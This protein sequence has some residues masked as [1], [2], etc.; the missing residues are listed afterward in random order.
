[1]TIFLQNYIVMN[2]I[3]I[4]TLEK[5]SQNIYTFVTLLLIY[6]DSNWNLLVAK[7]ESLNILG[8]SIRKD[9]S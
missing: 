4:K 9:T 2:R 3:N 6:P 8:F 7:F 5:L 1:M